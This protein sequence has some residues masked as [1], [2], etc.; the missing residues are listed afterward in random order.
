MSI[1]EVR[2]ADPPRSLA[3]C[4]T[5]ASGALGTVPGSSPMLQSCGNS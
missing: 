3:E 2:L 1:A 5:G 4:C